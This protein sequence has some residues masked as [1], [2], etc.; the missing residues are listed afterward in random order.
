MAFS[1]IHEASQMT[2]HVQVS[3]A[4]AQAQTLAA[5]L[6]NADT[7]FPSTIAK[8]GSVAASSIQTIVKVITGSSASG[9][10]AASPSGD[11][12]LSLVLIHEDAQPE[13]S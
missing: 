7:V 8:A 3:Q 1:S 6:Q 4:T 5:A 2:A 10:P 9:S 11:K 13:A 12:P